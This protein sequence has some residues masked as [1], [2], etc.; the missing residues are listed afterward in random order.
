M[1]K[2][3]KISDAKMPNTVEKKT[4]NWYYCCKLRLALGLLLVV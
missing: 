1:T 4:A 3:S 2:T